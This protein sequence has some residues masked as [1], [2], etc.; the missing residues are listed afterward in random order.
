MY[1]FIKHSTNIFYLNNV[2]KHMS[3]ILYI[4]FK[5]YNNIVVPNWVGLDPFPKRG[6]VEAYFRI[7]KKVSTILGSVLSS[8]C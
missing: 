7:S 5:L 4:S 6:V 3:N 8:F 2:E 1:I